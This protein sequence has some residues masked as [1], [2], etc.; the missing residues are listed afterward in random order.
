MSDEKIGLVVETEYD[1]NAQCEPPELGTI[2]TIL[3]MGQHGEEG[4][5][6]ASVDPTKAQKFKWDGCYI[7]KEMTKLPLVIQKKIIALMRL[8]GSSIKVDWSE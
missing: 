5:K 1:F 8:A 6:L 7:C 3:P 4:L 2:V